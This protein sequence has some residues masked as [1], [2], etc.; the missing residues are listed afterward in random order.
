MPKP[1]EFEMGGIIGQATIADCVSNS[2]SRWFF[3]KYGFVLRD[4]KPLPFRGYRGQ[5]GFFEV[6]E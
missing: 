5:L 6:A 3:G 1:D 2:E 4:G